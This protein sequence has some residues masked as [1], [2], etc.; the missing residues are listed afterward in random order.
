MSIPLIGPDGRE[1]ELGDPAQLPAAQAQG[2]RVV[3]PDAPA[4]LGE[5]VKGGL[6][7]A[8]DT[9]EA[10]AFGVLQGVTGGGFG[11]MQGK[12]AAPK[13]YPATDAASQEA[14]AKQAANLEAHPVAKGVGEFVGMVASPIN[15][16]GA[17]VRGGIGA[18]TAIGRIGAAAAGGGVEG[19]LYGAGNTL[20]DA[21][22]GDYDLTGEK[23]AAGIGLGGLLGFG[24]AGVGAG[25]AEGFRAAVPAAARLAGK[26]IPGLE[27][28]ADD[29]WLKAGG[30]IQSSIKKIPD[31]ERSAVADELRRAMNP[32]GKFVPGTLDDA[33][34]AIGIE[35]D[36]TA[37]QLLKTIGVDDAGGLL[38]AM[39]RDAA[40]EAL[41][42]GF[43]VN[44]KRVG[45]VLDAADAMGARPAPS[46]FL[47]RFDD[48]EAGLNP[49]ERDLVA[50]DLDDARRYV[51]E[52][53]GKPPG[54]ASGFGALNDLKS[55]LQ[56]DI[57]WVADS[58]AK[59]SLKKQLV[60]IFRDE[61]DTQLAPQI[62]ADLSKEFLAGK[63]AY[64]ALKQAAKS[65]RGKNATGADAIAALIGNSSA[66]GTPEALRMSALEHAS[67]LV[68]GGMD[69]ELGNRWLSLSDYLTGLTG[70]VVAGHP[71]GALAGLAQSVGH[72]VFR[73][74]GAGMVAALADKISKSPMLA[75]TAASFGKQVQ[76]AP[77]LG[78]YAAP[79]LQ[80]FAHSPASGLATHMVMAQTDPDYAAAA[81]AAGFLPETPEEAAHATAKAGH[82]AAV[83]HTLDAQNQK[84]SASLDA[85]LKGARSP[86][87]STVM[88]S[89]DFGA[90][91]MR[92]EGLDAHRTRVDEIRALAAD[93]NALLER[94][95]ANIGDTSEMA[96]GVAAAMTRTAAAAVA[97][98]AKESR[99]P[100]KPGP[101]GYD[102]TA[103]EAEREEFAQ[104]LEAVQEPLSVLKYAAAGTMVPEQW[105]AVQAVYPLLAAQIRDEALGRL[106]DPPKDVPY[107]ARLMLDML[108]GIDPDG[109]FGQGVALN[110]QTIASAAVSEKPTNPAKTEF[111]AGARM[112]TQSQR[113]EMDNGE[114]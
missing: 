105:R 45:A 101:L 68:K 57:N 2:Y 38:P 20:S 12:A 33:A 27:D 113:R 34:G 96:P 43:D 23:L 75:T 47:R 97:Y 108:T 59:N 54:K 92:K 72:K 95:T 9:A 114:A 93:P 102:W 26:A 107:R 88:K 7:E 111:G 44:A 52:I 10:G 16:V 66:K 22:L 29:R 48:F 42:K 67:R 5:Q 64:G 87:A 32:N 79:L 106:V 109:T 41:N 53:G 104:K 24:G 25:L 3:T 91:R 63:E 83:A 4:T 70:A 85:V 37:K 36:A 112:A 8:K 82:L 103:P 55:S 110:Q 1:Y 46:R 62:G 21:A 89:Q 58:G 56:K 81:E 98:L 17:A 31:A 61:I 71:L 40:T 90:K 60:G 73:E 39:D 74:R 6:A 35:R 94:F 51:L 76:N 13:G 78:K 99:Q 80:A 15:K 30:G 18:T 11:Y 49:K 100:P 19:M 84:I 65:L 28:F 14:I 86:P 69:R 50:K 77:E